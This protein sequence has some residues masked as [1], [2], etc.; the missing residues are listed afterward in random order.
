MKTTVILILLALLITAVKKL[1]NF[2]TYNATHQQMNAC[3]S[4]NGYCD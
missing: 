4:Y 3:T 2:H 1:D